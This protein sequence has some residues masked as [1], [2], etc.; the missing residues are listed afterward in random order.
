MWKTLRIL[1]TVLCALCL[2]ALFLVGTFGDL[3][4]LLVTLLAAAI[5]FALMLFCK[6]KQES[7][8]HRDDPPAPDFMNTDETPAQ[9][10][11]EK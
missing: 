8:K 3:P 4:W 2:A 11:E 10:D 5:F 6:R 9:N 7:L 1:F